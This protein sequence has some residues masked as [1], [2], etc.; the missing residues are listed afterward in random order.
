MARKQ[1]EGGTL[2]HAL[3]MISMGYTYA[4]VA[5]RTKIPYWLISG[6]IRKVP[7]PMLTPEKDRVEEFAK[8]HKTTAPQVVMDMVNLYWDDYVS[9]NGS[10][11]KKKKR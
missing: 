11:K 4:E 9:R 6:S 5:V 10:N 2:D 3:A 1:L 8:L 7:V